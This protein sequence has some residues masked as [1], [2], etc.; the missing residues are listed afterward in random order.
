VAVTSVRTRA[1]IVPDRAWWSAAGVDLD[2]AGVEPVLDPAAADTLVV[3]TRIPAGLLDAVHELQLR[4]PD[5]AAVRTIEGLDLA[6]APAGESL[7]EP[8]ARHHAGTA[9]DE[10][11]D[12]GDDH[13]HDHDHDMMAVTGEPSVD[14]LVMEDADLT[15][16]PLG[17]ALPSGLV[18]E[19]TL[20]G[21]VVRAA[22]IS[23]VLPAHPTAADQLSPLAFRCASERVAGS[24]QAPPAPARRVAAVETERA[25]SH[26]VWLARFARLIGWL[27]AAERLEAGLKPLVAAQRSFLRDEEVELGDSGDLAAVLD[28]LLGSRRL[29][30]RTAGIAVVTARTCRAYGVGG[31]TAR[32]AGLGDDAR[33]ADPAYRALDFTPV[34]RARG[35]A[36]S[37]VEVRAEEA[38]ASLAL[39]YSATAAGAVPAGEGAVE[40]PRGPLTMSGAGPGAA[41]GPPSAGGGTVDLAAAA[42]VGHELARALVAVAS[43]D[44][45]PWQVAR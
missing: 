38:L 9:S 45:S 30:R 42:A 25:L 36:H 21:D 7:A 29:A 26:S 40:G 4:Q 28:S 16:G 1:V 34:T 37:R 27:D 2:A 39:A 22:A 24:A 6:G 11:A 12:E 5:P 13:D 18:L 8:F 23:S 32:A 41:P 35:D 31:P 15:V 44:L 19:L 20:D 43:F 14:G 10:E 33:A 17:S 3:P